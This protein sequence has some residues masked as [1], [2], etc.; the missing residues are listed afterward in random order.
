MRCL[1]LSYHHHIQAPHAYAN[2]IVVCVL[3]A[4]GSSCTL[5]LKYDLCF[6]VKCYAQLYLNDPGGGG[7]IY[8]IGKTSYFLQL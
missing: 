2:Y 4:R 5:R 1:D 6:I 8:I 3:S 7:M